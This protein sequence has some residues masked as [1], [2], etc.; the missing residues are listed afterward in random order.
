MYTRFTFISYTFAAVAG[1]CLMGGIAVLSG[2][3]K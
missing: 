2:G 1:I 3:R